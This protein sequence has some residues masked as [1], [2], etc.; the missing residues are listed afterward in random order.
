MHRI[1]TI[2]REFGSGGR[3]IGARLATE[4][5]YAYYDKEIISAIAER[6]QLAEDYVNQVVESQIRTYDNLV[7]YSTVYLN[8]EEVVK[9]T[10][11]EKEGAFARMGKGF[12]E[13][14]SDVGTAIVE[15]FVWLVSHLPQILLSILLIIIIISPVSCIH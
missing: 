14:L 4:L 11:V 2:G 8:I 6:S 10:P 7:D 1:I 5:G 9:F 12:M 3:E 15:F 13:N